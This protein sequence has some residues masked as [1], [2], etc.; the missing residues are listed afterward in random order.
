MY[1]QR[2]LFSTR[3]IFVRFSI[4]STRLFH[5]N[6]LSF[7]FYSRLPLLANAIKYILLTITKKVNNS[8]SEWMRDEI[9][10]V[11]LDEFDSILF[12]KISSDS[13]GLTSNTVAEIVPY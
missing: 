4:H 11:G 8:M 7:P 5:I 9:I 12:I 1:G 13:G 10:L 6:S 3:I 2:I